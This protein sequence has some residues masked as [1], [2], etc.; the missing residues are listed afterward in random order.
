MNLL[1]LAKQFDTDFIVIIEHFCG[2]GFLSGLSFVL[3]LFRSAALS[4][5]RLM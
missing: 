5:V 3:S 4:H 2:L 1:Y